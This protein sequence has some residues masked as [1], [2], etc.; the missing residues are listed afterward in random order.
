MSNQSPVVEYE[1]WIDQ[2]VNAVLLYIIC[3]CN[4]QLKKHEEL[5]AFLTISLYTWKVLD[6]GQPIVDIQV[7]FSIDLSLSWLS[8]RKTLNIMFLLSCCYSGLRCRY[9]LLIDD[10]WELSALNEF[11]SDLEVF[12]TWEIIWVQVIVW[13]RLKVVILSNKAHEAFR[14]VDTFKFIHN[15]YLNYWRL[16]YKAR[17]NLAC[18]LVVSLFFLNLIDLWRLFYQLF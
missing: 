18:R 17:C 16:Y 6:Y 14:I 2:E 15:K 1:Y 7:R 10:F 5:A 11:I 8:I 9:R 4:W 12:N 3:V 13:N